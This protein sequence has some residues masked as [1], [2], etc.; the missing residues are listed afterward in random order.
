[1][2]DLPLA[3]RNVCLKERVENYR[4]FTGA[5]DWSPEAG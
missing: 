1:M 3:E 5:R 4:A 2:D